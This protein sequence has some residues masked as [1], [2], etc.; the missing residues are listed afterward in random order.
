VGYGQVHGAD[1]VGVG[2]LG[3]AQGGESFGEAEGAGG[4]GQAGGTGRKGS[5]QESGVE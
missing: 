4:T 1:E 2:G 3:G 5:C